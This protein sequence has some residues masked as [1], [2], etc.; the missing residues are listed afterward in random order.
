[1]NRKGIISIVKEIC[2]QLADELGYELVDV[3]FLK[4]GSNYFLRVYL[5]KPGGINL[6]DCQKVS[7]L[8]SDKLDEKDPITTP[9]YLEVSSPGLDRPLKNDKD[10]KRNLGKEI[11][12]KLYEPL[13]GKK[14][15]EGILEDYEEKTIVI[16]TEINEIVTIPKEG[17]ALIK[18][19]VK[20]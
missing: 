11:E 17:I 12:I 4:E 7:Q 8:L 10:L 3:E 14:I 2:E 9:Y 6:D 16:R 1:M 19:A 20:F 5:D 13:K 18:L 15:I